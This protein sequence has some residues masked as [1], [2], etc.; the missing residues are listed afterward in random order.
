MRQDAYLEQRRADRKLPVSDVPVGRRKAYADKVRA[1]TEVA[2]AQVREQLATPDV[3]ASF[4]GA[5]KDGI[6]ERDRTAL[7]LYAQV[8]KLVGEERKLIVEFVHSM[9]AKSEDELRRMFMSAKQAEGADIVTAIE[10]C[11][12]FL[13][14]AL[15]MHEQHRQVVI[16]R[17]GGYLPVDTNAVGTDDQ[18]IAGA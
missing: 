10:R 15:P 2:G 16:R 7:N 9:G 14:G 12:A 13:E 11:T 1:L 5:I 4:C 3:V 6:V 17:L 18:P 8:M